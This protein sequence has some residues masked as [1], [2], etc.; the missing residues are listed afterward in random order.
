MRAAA[1]VA[2]LLLTGC[3][4]GRS[5]FSCPMPNGIACMSAR[6]VYNRSVAGDL[7]KDGPTEVA[8]TGSAAGSGGQPPMDRFPLAPWTNAPSLDAPQPLRAPPKIM[9]IWVPPFEDKGGDLHMPS[10]VYVELE[11]RR[12]LVGEREVPVN[13]RLTPIDVRTSSPGASAQGEPVPAQSVP[14]SQP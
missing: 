3:T 5:D 10:L 8:G 6:E 14:S 2:L 9:R 11:P 7:N 12:W 1:S 13:Q 4:I